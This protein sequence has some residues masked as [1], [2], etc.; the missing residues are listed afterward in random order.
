M[1]LNA[2]MKIK[3]AVKQD[4]LIQLVSFML[5]NE[6]YGVEV[7]KVREIIRIPP[8]TRMPNAAQH[9]E[10]IINLRGKVTGGVSV[11][12]ILSQRA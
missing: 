1:A 5:N 6:E 3:E 7:L 2:L 4:E 9:V 10:G 12:P 8:I 11:S